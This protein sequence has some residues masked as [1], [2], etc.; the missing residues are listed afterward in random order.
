VES[1]KNDLYLINT[2]RLFEDEV[3]KGFYNK[4]VLSKMELIEELLSSNQGSLESRCVGE[5]RLNEL[6]HYF[7]E[8]REKSTKTFNRILTAEEKRRLK[9]LADIIKPLNE[10]IETVCEKGTPIE[11]LTN[12]V[13]ACIME[14]PNQDY[15]GSIKL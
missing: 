11:Y 14:T 3:K 8:V 15:V 10:L 4:Y 7:I 12:S 13:V 5:H 6:T 1:L 9:E 2:S